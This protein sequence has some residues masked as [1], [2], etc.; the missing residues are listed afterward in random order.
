[1]PAAPPALHPQAADPAATHPAATQFSDTTIT[2]PVRIDSTG[3][4][5]NLKVVLG[6][7]LAHLPC[8]ILLCEEDAEPRAPAFLPEFMDR[9]G[10]SFLQSA[11][12]WFH[13][14]RCLNRMARQAAT[15]KLLSHDADV[16]VPPARYANAWLLAHEGADLVLPYDGLCLNVEGEHIAR[17]WRNK[18]LDGLGTQ[19]CPVLAPRLFGGMALMRRESFLAAGMENEHFL[20]W[21]GEDDERVTRFGRLGFSMARLAGPLFHLEHPRPPERI[22]VTN[23]RYAENEREYEKV[24]AMSGEELRAYVATWPWLREGE[25]EETGTG[26]GCA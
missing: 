5:R 6:F 15:P 23:P 14:T 19:N 17:V 21:G 22:G 11:S 8:P 9:V 25:A 26:G 1:M 7:L 13:K 10:Y 18:S 12:P 24:L 4:A 16:L 20:S 3:R 2:I